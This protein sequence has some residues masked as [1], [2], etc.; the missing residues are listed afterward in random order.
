MSAVAL[1]D[2]SV[3][4]SILRVPTKDQHHEEAL[5]ELRR[6]IQERDTLLLPLATIYETGNHVAQNGDGGTRRRVATT[7]VSQVQQAFSGEAPWTPTP[8]HAPEEFVQWLAEFPDHAMRGVGLGD[9]SIVKTWETQCMLHPARRV[10]IWSYDQHLA[11]Y[12][13]R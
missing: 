5:R 8:L 6:L 11:G 1:I 7:F 13:R 3:F 12:D 10:F 2:T 9:L 4:C